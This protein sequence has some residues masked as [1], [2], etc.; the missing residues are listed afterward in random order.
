LP[1]EVF[2]TE[3]AEKAPCVEKGFGTLDMG[4]ITDYLLR[5]SDRRFLNRGFG[6]GVVTEQKIILSGKLATAD[7]DNDNK[8]EY[9]RE[10]TSMEGLHLTVWSGK[11][12]K[13]RIIWHSYYGL[14][15]DTEP[16]CKDK[17]FKGLNDE[18]L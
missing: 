11:P 17:D 9:F 12:L 2:E 8:P 14:G 13:G 3:I 1:Q 5:S 6:I 15:Y 18:D 7:I 4:Y 16:T 10:C